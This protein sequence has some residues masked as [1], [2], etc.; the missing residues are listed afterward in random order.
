MKPLFALVDCNNF[1]VSCERAFD[2]RLEGRPMVVLSNNDGCI[3]ARSNEAKQLG[4]A[5]GIPAFQVADLLQKHRVVTYSSNYALY[6]DMSGR[7]MN[8]LSQF[9][10]EME[11]YSIDE[12]FLALGPLGAAADYE[13]LARQIRGRVK[14]WTGIPVSIGL[15]ATKTLAKIANRLAKKN[16]DAQG[17]C[18]LDTPAALD[19]ALPQ[20]EVRDIWGVGASTARQ[21]HKLGIVTAAALRAAGTDSIRRR[22]G[23]NGLRT[24]YELRGECCYEL[25]KNPPVKQSL[26]VSRSFGMPL[27]KADKLAEA[28]ACFAV[29]A[30]EK[31]R[32]EGLFAGLATIFVMTDRFAAG[33]CYFARTFALPRFS[34]D[35]RDFLN[36]A[37]QAAG[38]LFFAGGRFKRG[39]IMLGELSRLRQGGLFDNLDAEKSMR[40]MRAIDAINARGQDRRI[41]FAAEGLG[42][43]PAWQSRCSHRSGRYTTRWDELP[44]VTCRPA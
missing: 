37:A 38:E 18:L 3:V 19:A 24:L 17:V 6:G 11:I 9:T 42:P 22:F 40:L 14:Q 25:E 4:I 44:V 29:R 28:L 7:V 1:Y 26:G 43:K 13:D 2:P 20:I 34:D 35:S 23:V 5:M 36:C 8:I 21:L 32:A 12:A 39:G 30:A 10:P 31:L 33:P 41:V 15:G 27:T 16:P